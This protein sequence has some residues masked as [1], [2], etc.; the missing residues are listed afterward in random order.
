MTS[1]DRRKQMLKR[2]VL[3]GAPGTGK[4]TLAHALRQRGHSVVDEAATDVIT[5][6]RAQGVDQPWQRPDFLEAITRLQRQRQNAPVSSTV[7]VQIYDRSP[8]CTLALARY[9]HRSVPP[10]LTEEVARMINEQLYQRRVLLVQPLGFI[11][12]TA[13]RRITYQDSLV[14][15]RI[16]EAVYREH[17]YELVDVPPASVTERLTLVEKLIA[18]TAPLA[19]L[20]RWCAVDP[21]TD[22]RASQE[23]PPCDDPRPCLCS[24][25]CVGGLPGLHH[26]GE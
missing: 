12:P 3:T 26:V 2:Y 5:T 23:E 4:T 7:A 21:P 11:T 15:H 25:P 19:L 8:L 22:P 17:S 18:P 13:A 10:L 20:R 24:G 14:F 16:H 6:Q 9:L 1:S